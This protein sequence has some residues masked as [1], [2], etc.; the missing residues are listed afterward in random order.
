MVRSVLVAVF[1][2]LVPASPAAAA[3]PSLAGGDVLS[4][5]GASTC[6]LAFN[7]SGRNI[8]TGS[9]CGPVG[10]RWY[11]GS[12]SVGVISTVLAGK[13]AAI[14][15]IDNPAVLQLAAVR[16]GAVLTPIR[17][18]ARAYVAQSVTYYSPTGG[19]RTGTV[20]GVNQTVN[21]AG[22][23]LTGLDRINLCA[24]VR[25][26]GAP[27]VAGSTAL[28]LISGGSGCGGAGGSLYAQPVVPVLLATGL[29]IYA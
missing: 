25:D 19:V 29:A 21:F 1:L 23:T 20:T 18:A 14:L 12:V 9:R 17:A 5:P 8:L 4:Q 22:G 3:P 16:L 28:S 13:D 27:V 15:H 11:A 26:G 6:Q 10:T 7:L 2:V 24:G